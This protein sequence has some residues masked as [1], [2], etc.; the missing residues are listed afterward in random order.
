[1][2]FVVPVGCQS[3]NIQANF[4]LKLQ[5]KGGSGAGCCCFAHCDYFA[6]FAVAILVAFTAKDAKRGRKDRQ[7]HAIAIRTARLP[8]RLIPREI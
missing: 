7:E 1:M 2:F 8:K 6:A 4:L 3:G 5:G